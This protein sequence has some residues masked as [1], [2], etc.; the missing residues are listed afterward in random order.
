MLHL[1]HKPQVPSSVFVA[2]S[3]DVIGAV[4][5]G[6]Q[7]SVWFQVVLRADV[8]PI[9]IGSKT[10]IQDGTVIHGSL[11]KAQ[12]TIGDGVTVGH[13]VMLHGCTI[14]DD[15][16]VGMGACIM[17]NALIKKNCIVAAGSLVTEKAT[18]EEGSLILGSPAK[19]VRKLKPEELE[20][21]KTN[22][23]HYVKYAKSYMTSENE[24][25]GSGKVN[26]Y[27]V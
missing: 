21:I 25:E 24:K 23:D 3:S 11:G 4:D 19:A 16:L 14:E 1:D 5:I 22:A 7:S 26:Y 27:K 13:K 18:F 10:N 8:M 20:W 6:E 17:D 12:T 2:G 15:V 9:K